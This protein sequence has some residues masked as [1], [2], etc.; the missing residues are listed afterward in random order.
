MGDLSAYLKIA[1]EEQ[2]VLRAT[3]STDSRARR[4]LKHATPPRWRG[5]ARMLGTDI[6]RPREVRRARRL[7]TAKPLLLHLGSGQE[8]KS[9]W[10]NVDLIGDPVDLSWNLARPLPFEDGTVDGIFHEHLLEHLPLG[11]GAAFT[12]ECARVLR[13]GGTLRIGVPDIATLIADYAN[14]T[15]KLLARKPGRPTALLAL[16]EMFY[17]HR[18]CAMYD[19]ETLDVL[20][21]WAGLNSAL[22]SEWG[23]ST[24]FEPVPDS[25]RR[26]G[27]TLYV[28]AVAS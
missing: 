14:G 12:R 9:G 11:A 10:I 21:R 4:I 20:V 1:E 5:R 7:S 2:R 13:P 28:E 3:K 17:W 19:F 16:Q 6:I 15:G 24:V 8:R 25:E 27:N 23:R 18:H 26:R 22:R